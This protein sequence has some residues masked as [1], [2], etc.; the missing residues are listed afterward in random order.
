MPNSLP[1]RPE[2]AENT[3]NLVGPHVIIIALCSYL[4]TRARKTAKIVN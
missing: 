1:E 4:N 3:K 2:R